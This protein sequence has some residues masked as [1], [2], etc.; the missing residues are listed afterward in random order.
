[1][2]NAVVPA[3]N[4]ATAGTAL[5]TVVNPLP[6]GRRSNPAFFQIGVPE[7]SVTFVNAPKSPLAIPEPAA[8]VAADFN[9]DGKPHLAIARVIRVYVLPGNGNRTFSPANG[10]PPPVASPPYDYFWT[11]VPGPALAVGDFNP[12]GHA[13]LAFGLFQNLAAAILLGN[14]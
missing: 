4:L 8:V 11:P 7:A 12:S 6:G 1:H 9:E 13:G 5:V 2:L 10:S 3:A 14:G